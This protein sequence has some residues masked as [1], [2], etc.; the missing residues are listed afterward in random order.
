MTDLH[1]GRSKVGQVE[2]RRKRASGKRVIDGK[3]YNTTRPRL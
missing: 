1:H 3:T 2:M